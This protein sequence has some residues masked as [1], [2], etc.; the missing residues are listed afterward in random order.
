[1][2]ART[3]ALLVLTDW[4]YPGWKATVDGQPARIY[5]ADYVFRG[6]PVPAGAVVINEIMFN[7]A[8]PGAEYVELFNTSTTNAFDLSGW[9]LSGL[10]YTFPNG[11]FIAPR[12]Y[13]V[14]A[15]DRTAF[16]TAYGPGVLVFDEYWDDIHDKG[17]VVSFVR[18]RLSNSR[19]STRTR[20]CSSSARRRTTSR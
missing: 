19:R 8:L 2:D 11:A 7:P 15:K 1:M 9:T 10:S 13:L 3:P 12:G 5:S 20:A 14:L 17:A 18:K 4:D 6:V 16:S